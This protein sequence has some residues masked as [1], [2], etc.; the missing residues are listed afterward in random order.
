MAL[1]PDG[2]R[3]GPYEILAPLGAGGMGDVYRGRD[4]RLGRAVAIKLL[5]AELSGDA[6]SRTRFEREARS[7]AALTHPH[8]CTVH[9]VG[10]HEGNAFL[11]ME[12]LEGQTLAAR[13]ARTKGGLPLDEALTIAAHVAEALAFAHRHH[14]THR[15]IKPANIM[16]TPTG[17]KLLDFGLALLRDRD[18]A[19]GQGQTQSSLTGPLGVVGTLAYMSPEQ[20]DG[21]ADERSDI[22]AFGAVLFE[23]LTG[24]KAFDGATSSAVIG[25]VVQTDP[26]EVSSL[27]PDVSPP[28]ERVVRRCL[29]K[30]PDARW[31]S[32]MD[33]ADELKW[34]AGN[35]NGAGVIATPRSHPRRLV[36]AALV[37]TTAVAIGLAVRSQLSVAPALA[38]A[39]VRFVVAPPDDLS[40]WP[41]MALSPD[42]QR[43]ALVTIDE[44][45]HTQLWLRS[46]ASEVVERVA[47]SDGASYPFWSPD[48]QSIGFF[49]DGQLKRVA[50]AGGPPIV[51]CAAEDGRG[52][53]WN[54]GGVIVFAPRTFSA[55]MR[56]PASGGTPQPVTQLDPSTY[57]ANR[58]PH[59]LPDGDHFLYLADS[60]PGGQSALR[61]GSLRDGDSRSVLEEV[62]EG[63]YSDGLLF[64]VRGDVLLAQPFDLDRLALGGDP[65]AV[66]QDIA[67]RHSGQKAFSVTP[68]GTL[69]FLRRSDM[70][71]VTQLTWFNRS[72]TRTGNVGQPGRFGD[73]S[74]APDGRRLAVTRFDGGD[75]IWVFERERGTAARLTSP[76]VQAV[77]SPEGS[78]VVFSAIPLK[79]GPTH[80]LWTIAA[81][82]SGPAAPLIESKFQ[83]RAQGWTPDGSRLLY[84]LIFGDH[85]TASG[86]WMMTKPG[87]RSV[88]FR[89]D[90]FAYPHAALSPDGHWVA[91][92]S[93]QSGR[94]EI[95]VE[96]F[97]TPGRRV[98]VSTDG[99]TQPRWRR[100]QKEL[101]FLSA[102]SRLIAVPANLGTEA[103]LGIP[104]PLFALAVPAGTIGWKPFH[105]DVSADGRFLAA[106]VEPYVPERPPI[107]VAVNATAGLKPKP[108][109]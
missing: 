65:Q 90:G 27:R 7:I 24:R 61:V 109:R 6:I 82:G 98:Q 92:A 15:D 46:M 3:L 9:D 11:V 79:G 100:D 40:F 68:G 45:L 102:E 63:Q 107:T 56:V 97:P 101:Y 32:T 2:A 17:V 23:M 58:W 95:Y 44:K 81:D 5:N 75:S 16:L 103:M 66:A 104:T 85:E 49:A 1:L 89:N 34:I 76:G 20:L 67:G 54:K 10:D 12:L 30:N 108:L 39:P 36:V 13:L 19:S 8:I 37:V 4:T 99:G 38:S 77:W 48:S 96:S 60:P 87:S 50:A 18:E 69:A 84:Q 105:Y 73:V 22:F 91:Y 43:L 74:I 57:I 88:P 93:N 47:G 55:L 35:G 72:G 28:L 106:I 59:F 21:H 71:P 33:L 52:A 41:T 51:I 78:R 94:F 83:L 42:G 14:I 31:Q 53:T 80:H 70:N 64:F 25:A 29:A 26:P 86:L 62:T